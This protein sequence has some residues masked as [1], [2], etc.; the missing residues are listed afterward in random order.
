MVHWVE[1]FSFTIRA[2]RRD[3]HRFGLRRPLVRIFR[4]FNGPEITVLLAPSVAR[5]PRRAKIRYP[6]LCLPPL[7]GDLFEPAEL[8]FLLLCFSLNEL[9]AFIELIL[10]RFGFCFGRVCLH[11]GN[12]FEFPACS[13][14]YQIFVT[15]NKNKT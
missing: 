7:V 15:R 13:L 3:C 5:I 11:F 4:Q 10:V 6:L 12:T 2:K 14:F 1:Q 9:Q 8:G